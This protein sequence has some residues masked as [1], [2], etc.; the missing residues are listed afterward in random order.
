MFIECCG[1]YLF[2]FCLVFWKTQRIYRSGCKVTS[3]LLLEGLLTFLVISNCPKKFK[4]CE[5]GKKDFIQFELNCGPDFFQPERSEQHCCTPSGTHCHIDVWTNGVCRSRSLQCYNSYQDS[6]H[7]GEY[8]HYSCP[9]T[10]VSVMNDMCRGVT[11][12]QDDYVDCGPQLRRC[13]YTRY[14]DTLQHKFGW[15]WSWSFL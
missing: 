15:S 14:I 11:W 3:G 12:C 1:T 6:Q 2:S 7:I 4:L 13:S 10:C 9:N 5:N 8:S